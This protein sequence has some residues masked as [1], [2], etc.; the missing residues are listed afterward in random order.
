MP[1]IKKKFRV[2][3]YICSCGKR[4]KTY[5]K[6]AHNNTKYHKKWNGCPPVKLKEYAFIDFD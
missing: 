1:I 2:I 5:R 4:V 6:K 3:S